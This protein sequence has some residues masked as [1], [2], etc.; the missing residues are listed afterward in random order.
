MS[1]GRSVDWNALKKLASKAEGDPWSA[2]C[3]LCNFEHAPLLESSAGPAR[4]ED[5]AD[6]FGNALVESSG[7]S[8]DE[9][10]E[11]APDSFDDSR[12]RVAEE[13]RLRPMW[14]KTMSPATFQSPGER[15]E[16]ALAVPEQRRDRGRRK[17]KYKRFEVE[18]QR[19]E[20]AT[21]WGIFF[22]KSSG[23]GRRKGRKVSGVQRESPAALWQ[24]KCLDNRNLAYMMRYGD[25][26]RAVNGVRDGEDMSQELSSAVVAVLTFYR[27]SPAQRSRV[28]APQHSPKKPQQPQQEL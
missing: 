27:P 3:P 8:S 9:E 28:G 2:R 10:Q 6:D 13:V 22:F 4:P 24:Q 14:L 1:I 25:R 21:P 17:Q 19:G 15:A 26:L 16:N 23:T 11:F 5:D 12:L 18:L 7:S 20:V